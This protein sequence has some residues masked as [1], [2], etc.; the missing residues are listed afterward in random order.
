ME[1]VEFVAICVKTDKFPGKEHAPPLEL[2]EE[3]TI[4]RV[5]TCGCGEKHYDAQLK[6]KLNWVTC[7]KCGEELP[8]GMTWHWAHSSRFK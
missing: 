3:Y 1:K 6:S 4:L 5:Y 7:H 2:G 8:D